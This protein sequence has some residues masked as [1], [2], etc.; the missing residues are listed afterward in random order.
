MTIT[1]LFAAL[2]TPVAPDG[3]VDFD[4]LDRLC[5][6]LIERGVE[7]VCVGGATSEYPR[8]ELAE[9]RAILARVARRLPSGCSLLTAIGSSSVPRVIELGRAAFDL[10]SR[11]VL[12]P[13]PG[14]FGYR[15]DDLAAFCTQVSTELAGPCLLY[16]LPAFTNPIAPET[17]VALFESAPHIVGIKDSGGDAENLNRFARA[18]GDRDW[19]LLVGDDR[20]GLAAARTGWNGAI[21]GIACCCPELFVALWSS[22]RR[23]DDTEAARCQR[24]VDEFCDEFSSLPTPWAIRVALRARGVDTGPLALPLSAQ[25]A[26][27]VERFTQWF[28]TW[29]DRMEVPKLQAARRI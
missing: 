20:L 9:R 3:S 19:S 23:G 26:R 14:F 27:D 5:D 17:A 10:G 29:F 21:S 13:M 4:G 1:G 18:R 15:Q 7:G 16:D 2:A 28:A 12:L 11:A 8:F 6:F 25:R 22:L 24:L